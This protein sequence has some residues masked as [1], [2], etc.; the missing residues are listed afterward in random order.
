MHYRKKRK[1]KKWIWIFAA[2]LMVFGTVLLLVHASGEKQG[3][4]TVSVVE[5][6][7][8]V[9]LV[10]DGMEYSAY[11]GMM[12]QEGHEIVTSG[13]SYAR[14]VLDSDKYV[15]LESGSKLVFETLGVLGSG[16]TRLC[17]E[18]GALSTELVSPLKTDEE[19]VVN[20]P[21][22]VLAVRGT[23]FRVSVQMTRSGEVQSD[24]MTYG[25]RV[26]S[27]RILPSGEIVDEEVLIDAGFKTGIQRNADD[28]FY[29]VQ[30]MAVI[31]E[32]M[33][34]SVPCTEPI[35]TIDISDEDLVD[36]FY[37]AQNGHALFI[38]EEE[39]EQLLEERL[40]SLENTSSVYEKTME[41]ISE[42]LTYGELANDSMPLAR[43]E[44][45]ESE[46]GSQTGEIK[47]V[48]NQGILTDGNGKDAVKEDT[49]AGEDTGKEDIKQE[50][51]EEEERG[52]DIEEE[53][54]VEEDNSP[55]VVVPDNEQEEVVLPENPPEEVVLPDNTPEDITPSDNMPDDIV[56]PS[57]TPEDIVPPGNAEDDVI[58]PEEDETETHVHTEVYAG[59]EEIHSKCSVCGEV[60]TDGS[61]H[62]YTDTTTEATCTTAGKIE[63]TCEC[64][65]SY[66][67]EISALGH[68]EELV[69]EEEIHSKCST[70]GEVLTDGSAHDYTEAIT[71]ATCTESG[72]TV[73]TCECGYSYETPIPATGHTE[74]AGGEE[75]IHSK[76]SVCG[77]VLE[78]ESSHDYTDTTT[79]AT[80]TAAG[81][82]VYTCE[83]GYSYET[84]IP[85]TG[86]TEVAG[87]TTYVH[88]KCSVCETTLENG[89]YHSYTETN[90]SQPTCTEV[91]VNVFTCDCGYSF[92][93]GIPEL[94]HT[95]VAG[96][97]ANAHTKCQT[98]G[99]VILD[100]NYHSNG[101]HITPATCTEDGLLVKDCD[102]GYHYEEVLP[103]TGHTMADEYADVTHCNTCGAPRVSLHA[104]NFSDEDFCNFV[105]QYDLDNDEYL[106]GNELLDVTEMDVSNTGTGT[107]YYTLFGIKHFSN[108]TSLTC[109]DN[110][111]LPGLDVTDMWQLTTVDISGC[112]KITSLTLSNCYK[113]TTLNLTNCSSLNGKD[114]YLNGVSPE[115]GVVT[116]NITGTSLTQENFIYD[117]G[118]ITLQLVDDNNP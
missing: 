8:R 18:R 93:S 26:A 29:V 115:S 30:E 68:T 108:L 76:C 64:G 34:E 10:K 103:A 12:L 118:S 61:G 94:G 60:L 114:I 19:Y 13:D 66:E 70:C 52:E 96:G 85:A 21:N 28:T 11:P 42:A 90:I 24:V 84:S 104:I 101:S 17:L 47:V 16:K 15:K 33:G 27:K 45:E 41:V 22:A 39:T 9:G 14:L 35:E 69:G 36:I 78:D 95:E 54:P 113:L 88:S 57:N 58:P 71:P 40:V 3:Y 112:S 43:E 111:Q 6:S 7:G 89:N 31:P 87:G 62:D 106:L 63:Y 32:D 79:E 83:C 2:V 117:Y 59:E 25:G 105:R 109:K 81:K 91:G 65:Y 23:Y 97:T 99:E 100:G 75:E 102:C 49:V 50:V 72:K 73:Y 53:D 86:H 110:T 37:S 55:E 116:I 5:V 107:N 48:S 20:T 80:C 4:R 82:T 1:S 56:P 51:Q 44:Q 46:E 77:E 38:T 92:E 98:C 74:E 67:T